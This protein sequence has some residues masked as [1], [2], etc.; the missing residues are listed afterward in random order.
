[1][2]RNRADQYGNRG[3]DTPVDAG[4]YLGQVDSRMGNRGVIDSPTYQVIHF[5]SPYQVCQ[6]L[7]RTMIAI[8]PRK[9]P[10]L[11]AI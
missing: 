5:A 2:N 7:I 6:G 10:N 3:T 8:I 4:H 9:T 1:L 11:A